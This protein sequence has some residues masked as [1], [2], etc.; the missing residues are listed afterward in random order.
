M[1]TYGHA[2]KRGRA[3]VYGRAFTDNQDTGLSTATQ[4]DQGRRQGELLGFSVQPGHHRGE[5]PS[6]LDTHRSSDFLIADPDLIQC[7][8]PMD[9]FSTDTQRF[10]VEL[11]QHYT[12]ER[13]LRRNATNH[14][15]RYFGQA[16]ISCT[17]QSF[18]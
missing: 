12:G 17:R 1:Y 16:N 7:Q 3:A 4:A 11:Y 5:N 13:L 10:I 18:Y 6:V 14:D 8:K 2:T 15:H 9:R